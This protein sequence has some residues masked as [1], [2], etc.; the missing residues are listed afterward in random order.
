MALAEIVTQGWLEE[1]YLYGINLTNDTGD[2]YPAS[3]YRQALRSAIASI[4]RELSVCL[5]APKTVTGERHDHSSG[6]ERSYFLTFVNHRP[7]RAVTR[8]SVQYGTY[9]ATALPPSWAVVRNDRMGE[10]QIMP[11]PE[12][13]QAAAFPLGVT[14]FGVAGYQPGFLS[15]DYTAGFE[16]EGPGT[17]TVADGSTA[18]TGVGTTF[19]TS[20]ALP[21]HWIK[22][23]GQLREID[24]VHSET[25]LTV[26]DAFTADASAVTPT[27][28]LY[29]ADI[30]DAVGLAG[31]LLL[32]DTAGDLIIGAGIGNYSISFD[33]MSQSIGTTSG[34]ENSGFGARAIQYVKRLNQITDRLRD[35]WRRV[36]VASI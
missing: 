18:V 27:L 36:N 33:G 8:L 31:S 16:V 9:E 26:S 10:I 23:G 22:V 28:Y 11:G 5:A 15:L 32:L 20:G 30:L 6:R 25:S 4:E 13:I 19:L 14:G 29:D 1:R 12:G 21:G 34:V 3:L 35:T 2:P 24:L 17:A 7:L